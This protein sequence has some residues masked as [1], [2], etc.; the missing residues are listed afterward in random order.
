MVAEKQLTANAKL[1]ARIRQGEKLLGYAT[2]RIELSVSL[3]LLVE[4][5][6]TITIKGF[7]HFSGR[8][9]HDTRSLT[10]KA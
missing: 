5:F 1:I 9:T 6:K 2:R 3:I 10:I 7:L 8:R 4:R